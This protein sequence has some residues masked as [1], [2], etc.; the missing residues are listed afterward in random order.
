MSEAKARIEQQLG[1]PVHPV[2]TLFPMMATDELERLQRD[3]QVNGLKV[4][5]WTYEGK[6][7][8]GRNRLL[9]C[10]NADIKPTFQAWGGSGSLVR[11]AWSL[12][13]E[14]RHLN[15]SQK[16]AIAAEM[17]PLIEEEAAKRQ[18]HGQKQG[19]KTA[20]RGRAKADSYSQKTDSSNSERNEGKAA[21]EAAATTGT[22]RQYV[23]EAKK[24]KE[25]DPEEFEQVKAGKTTLPQVKRKIKE[26]K[27]EARRTENRTKVSRAPAV[28][29]AVSGARFATIVIDPPWDWNDEGDVNQMGR[30]KPDYATMSMEQLLQLPVEKLADDDCHLYLW[31]TNRSLPKGFPLLE[32]WGFRYVTAL[33]WVKPSF[34]LGN[35]FRGQHEHV[36]FAVRGSQGLRRKDV[37]TVFTADRGKRHSEKPA[38]F[39]DLVESCSPGPYLE[40]FSRSGRRDWTTWGEINA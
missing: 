5:I 25:E 31:I 24:L 23:A 39:L 21:A 3:I 8:D 20:G 4:P 9:A 27:R 19:G 17:L 10:R 37:G 28:D 26:K 34:G 12:N 14:R 40:M 7:I 38:A 22:N 16:A 6:V 32:R 2:C 30:A 35:Y 18:Q 33:V 13:G 15:S 1:M 29:V 11:F 36:L